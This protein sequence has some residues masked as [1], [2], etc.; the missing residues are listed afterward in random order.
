MWERNGSGVWTSAVPPP[1][2]PIVTSIF[3]SLV[4]RSSRA[5]LTVGIRPRQ[6]PVRQSLRLRRGS[7]IVAAVAQDPPRNIGSDTLVDLEQEIDAP[8][9]LLLEQYGRSF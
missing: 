6:P 7:S 5:V 1:S 3:V 4:V 2:R 9:R 8:T